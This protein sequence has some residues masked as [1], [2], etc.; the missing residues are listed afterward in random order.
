V[1]E[2]PTKVIA[3]HSQSMAIPECPNGWSELWIGYSFI[4]VS[5]SKK[6]IFFINKLFNEINI[7]TGRYLLRVSI[8]SIQ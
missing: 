4:M 6:Y 3:V 8:D 7:E 5:S 1:C 2:A